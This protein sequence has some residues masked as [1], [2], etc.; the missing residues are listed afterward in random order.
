M[1]K[2]CKYQQ[3]EHISENFNK[4]PEK[5]QICETL[6]KYPEKD[7][8]LRKILLNMQKNQ[9]ISGKVCELW[10]NK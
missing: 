8:N 2:F 5:K 4:Y 3:K 6:T 9:K 10:E 1:K 7:K